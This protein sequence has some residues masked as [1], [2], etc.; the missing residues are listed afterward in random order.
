VLIMVK[1]RV[2]VKLGLRDRCW[3]RVRGSG[4]VYFH[5]SSRLLDELSM[6]L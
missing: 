6:G 5:G 1:V 3:V 4:R 2:S